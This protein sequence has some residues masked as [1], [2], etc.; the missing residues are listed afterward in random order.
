MTSVRKPRRLPHVRE[1]ELGDE[2]LV[3]S[4]QDRTV[5][6]LN[7]FARAVWELCNGRRSLMQIHRR[8]ERS[9]GSAPARLFLDVESTVTRFVNEGLVDLDEGPPAGAAEA[10]A[11]DDAGERPEALHVAFDGLGVSIVSSSSRVREGVKRRLGRML[12]PRSPETVAELEIRVTGGKY[13]LLKN[14]Q[15]ARVDR[16]LE[17]SLRHLEGEAIQCFMAARPDL[18]WLHAAAAAAGGRAVIMSGLAGRGKSTL[19]TG[20][21]GHGWSYLS[22]ETVPVDVGAGRALPFPRTPIVREHR[23]EQIPADRLHELQRAEVEIAAE[24]ICREPP[25]I[26]ALVF[27][28]FD[29][30]AH[31]RLLYCSPADAAL[32]L[33]QNCLSFKSQGEAAVRGVVELVRRL[34]AFRLC[35]DHGATAADLL[36][37][38]QE[39]WYLD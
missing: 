30:S 31:T 16:S 26:G 10:E 8:L 14:G 37:R 24:L 38:A 22:D 36:V 4:G 5:V 2:L 29:A 9:L 21:C 28:V 17:P 15:Q 11:T 1:Y 33:L 18:L 20:L 34:P 13:L 25:A 19:V 23:G 6:S 12:V 39:N 32:D 7:P 35:F 27:P 3:Y